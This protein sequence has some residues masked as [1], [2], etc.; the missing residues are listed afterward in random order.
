L[1]QAQDLAGDRA[2]TW[3]RGNSN[4]QVVVLSGGLARRSEIRRALLARQGP[5]GRSPPRG[6][7]RLR[8]GL[9][10]LVALGLVV[11]AAALHVA[12]RGFG[13][14]EPPVELRFSP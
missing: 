14:T 6:L 13:Y 4:Q 5:D 11:I 3:M 7:Q 12:R 10:A 2:S 8:R 9:A 1:Q